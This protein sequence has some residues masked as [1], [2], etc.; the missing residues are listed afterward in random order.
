MGNS[1]GEAHA[2]WPTLPSS[3]TG[4]EQ[5]GRY[6][7]LGG[8]LHDNHLADLRE[9]LL[10]VRSPRA[11]ARCRRSCHLRWPGR[12]TADCRLLPLV[13]H[14][15]GKDT[16]DDLAADGIA[17]ANHEVVGPDAAGNPYAQ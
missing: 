16:L 8:A 15:E 1:F 5:T 10:A 3:A 4:H 7:L 2:G 6:A 17:Q 11:L 13:G 12:G 9:V 14:H